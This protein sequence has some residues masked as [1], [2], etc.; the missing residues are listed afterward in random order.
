[1]YKACKYFL[2][3]STVKLP[4]TDHGRCWL[5][6]TAGGK[7]YTKESCVDADTTKNQFIEV[8]AAQISL[9]TVN[10]I[11][12][13][14]D[15]RAR[16]QLHMNHPKYTVTF[17][18]GLGTDWDTAQKKVTIPRGEDAT[19]LS[20]SKAGYTF[21]GWDK[22]LTNVKGSF[23]TRAKWTANPYPCNF[24]P[25]GGTGTMASQTIAYDST[26]ALKRNTFQRQGYS[27]VGWST[28]KRGGAAYKNE[29]AIKMDSILG[30]DLY[31]VWKKNG[32]IS[33]FS[34]VEEDTG[35]FEGAVNLEGGN[36]TTYDA[37]HKDSGYSHTDE[38]G[39]P[40][41]FTGK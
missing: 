2:H 41:Y 40:G 8:G 31:A 6:A 27:F 9:R 20:P 25:N 37:Q 30:I 19:I 38:A 33:D 29:G 16:I 24:H 14:T 13:N 39:N 32:V 7:K 34:N 26:V 5:Y 11:R 17:D 28:T 4:S 35:M 12:Y 3:Y 22:D 1:F 21:N 23:T 10:G 36:G 18:A 15:R